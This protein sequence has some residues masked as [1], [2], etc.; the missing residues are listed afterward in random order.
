MKKIQWI[1]ISLFCSLAIVSCSNQY[2]EVQDTFPNGKK[3][4]ELIYE[5]EEENKKK[6]GQINYY[7]DGRVELTG[8]FNERGDRSGKWV[9]NY[10]NGKTWSE[11]DYIDGKREG[12]SVVFFENGKKRYQGRY[13]NDQQVGKWLFWNDQGELLFEK[14]F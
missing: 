3:K 8:F 14:E 11:C 12:G 9:Y 10:P 6:V 13:K 5:G 1:V 2:K 7:I 4:T